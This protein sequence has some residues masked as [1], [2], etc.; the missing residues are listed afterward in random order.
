MQDGMKELFRMHPASCILY[1][2]S[3]KVGIVGARVAGSY[4]ALLLSQLGHEVLLFDSTVEREK[5]CGGGITSKALHRMRWL[6]EHPIPRVEVA[7]I[8]LIAQDGYVS[9]LPLQHP[10][11]IFSRLSLESSLRQQAVESGAQFKHERVLSIV[12]EQPGWA[13]KTAAGFTG[14]DYIIGADGANS[15]VRTALVGRFS[16]DDLTLTLGYMIP[17]I[18]EPGIALIAFQES[19]FH[20]YLWSF[21]R[22]DHSS[23]GIGQWLPG[24]HI[25]D[26]RKRIDD[27][28]ESRYPD[29]G[30]EKKFYAARLPSLS[31][32]SLNQ[33]RICGPGWALLGDAA[34]FADSITGEGIYYALRSAELL[35]ES[36]YRGDPLSYEGAWRSDFKA[37]L[38]GAAI[39]RDRFYS[40]M[41]LS[42][43]FIR[44]SLQAVRYS[45]TVQKLLD[46]LLCGSISYKSLFRNLVFR[47]P[48][49]LL[50][51][52][53][54]KARYR[55]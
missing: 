21:P 44:R 49:I 10:I 5:P 34:G 43:T 51:V 39:W 1:P 50:Q 31:R 4:A 27:F 9:N 12:A 17:G 41:V 55:N 18:Y 38:E 25:P 47:S 2:S 22:V 11:H 42:Q 15:L 40:S 29:L 32:K 13:M 19:G 30:K 23:V 8:R 45:Q 28:V 48:S 37:D 53:R 3:M 46:M 6:H 16:S 26:L 24:V 33:Q 52:F 20:G 35:A 14:V 36:F 54:N 7:A